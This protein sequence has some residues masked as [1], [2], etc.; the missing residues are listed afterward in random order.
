MGAGWSTAPLRM[1]GTAAPSL[2]LFLTTGFWACFLPGKLPRSLLVFAN[3]T[4]PPVSHVVASGVTQYQH[5]RAA[6]ILGRW[7]R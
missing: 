3:A 6:D 7:W 2:D 5:K 4:T 1:L